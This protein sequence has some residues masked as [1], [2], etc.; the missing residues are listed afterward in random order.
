MTDFQLSPDLQNLF[1]NAGANFAGG[2]ATIWMDRLLAAGHSALRR[3]FGTPPLKKALYNSATSAINEIV[4]KRQLADAEYN[5][6]WKRFGAWLINSQVLDEF[7]VLF[8]PLEATTMDVDLLRKEFGAAGLAVEQFGA[9]DFETLLS[10][11]VNAFYVAASTEPL[12]QEPLKISVL[13]QIAKDVG[14]LQHAT[15]TQISLSQQS[16]AVQQK[17]LALQQEHYELVGDLLK[18]NRTRESS[19]TS[20]SGLAALGILS[21]QIEQ[22]VAKLSNMTGQHL[23]D[24]MAAWRKGNRSAAAKWIDQ[25]KVGDDWDLLPTDIRIRILCFEGSL[26]LES[27]DIQAARRCADA[28]A[29]LGE[30]TGEI[31]LRALIALWEHDAT[32]ALSV[33]GQPSD[34]AGVRLRAALLLESG[35][36]EQC[37]ALLVDN[38]K[39]CD[40]EAHRLRCLARLAVKDITGAQ[41]E[42]S[43]A[44]RLEPDWVSVR[45]ASAVVNYYGVM[46]L[47]CIPDRLEVWPEP[48][49][50]RLLRQDNRSLSGLHKAF[51]TFSNLLEAVDSPEEKFRLQSWC[52][53]CLAND[54]AAKPEASKYCDELLVSHPGSYQLIVWA[55]ARVLAIDWEKQVDW[56]C[57]E[58][59]KPTANVPTVL[60]LLHC[61]LSL[62]RQMDAL[63]L[64]DEKHNLFGSLDEKELWAVWKTQLLISVGKLED[65]TK[66]VESA[67]D[68]LELAPDKKRVLL[69]LIPS[70]PKSFEAL[71]ELACTEGSVS[72]PEIYLAYLEAKLEKGHWSDILANADSIIC[73]LDVPNV[74]SLV[75]FS[76]FYSGDFE[77]CLHILDT[78]APLFPNER[79]PPNLRRLTAKC[80][81]ELGDLPTAVAILQSL[82]AEVPSSQHLLD[83]AFLYSVT[84]DLKNL[85]IV[86]REILTHK[87]VLTEQMLQLAYALRLEDKELAIEIWKHVASDAIPDSLIFTALQLGFSLE[88]EFDSRHKELLTKLAELASTGAEGVEEATLSEVADWFRKSRLRIDHQYSEYLAG[89]IPVHVFSAVAHVPLTRIYCR[90]FIENSETADPIRQMPI[91]ARYGGKHERR[92]L[93]T[94]NSIPRLNADI[95]ALLLADQLDILSVVEQT[96]RPIGVSQALMDTLGYWADQ[97]ASHQ[98]SQMHVKR[99]IQSLIDSGK[100]Q[101]TRPDIERLDNSD[102]LVVEMGKEWTAVYELAISNSGYV[103]DYVPLC[104]VGLTDELAVVAETVLERVVNIRCIVEALSTY[105]RLTKAEV[106]G[107]LDR[108]GTEG[109]VAPTPVVP[110]RKATLYFVN[111]TLETLVA[112]GIFSDVVATF[113]AAVTEEYAR[114]LHEEL[115]EYD[116]SQKELSQLRRLHRLIGAG[117]GRG[118]YR[119]LP[120]AAADSTDVEDPLL[121]CLRDLL[122]FAASDQDVIWIDDRYMSSFLRRGNNQIV[123]ITEVLKLLVV[124]KAL[125]QDAYYEKLIKLREAGVYYLP[126]TP[127]ELFYTLGTAPIEGYR[128]IETAN[129]RILR[130]YIAGCLLRGTWLQRP[131]LPNTAPNPKG[132]LDFVLE[133]KHSILNVLQLLWSDESQDLENRIAKSTWLLECLDLDIASLRWSVWTKPVQDDLYV[134]ATDLAGYLSVGMLGPL[135]TSSRTRFR[136]TDYFA[137]LMQHLIGPRIRTEPSLIQLIAASIKQELQAVVYSLPDV[138]GSDAAS[139]EQAKAILGNVYHKLPEVFQA[140]LQEDADFTRS[141]GI[142]ILTVA[143]VGNLRFEFSQ[144]AEAVATC[145]SGREA[146]IHTLDTDMVIRLEP[147]AERQPSGEIH[148]LEPLSGHRVVLSDPALGLLSPSSEE[149]LNVLHHNRHWFEGSQSAYELAVVELT[150]EANPAD[151]L[152]QALEWAEHSVEDFYQRLQRSLQQSKSFSEDELIG[153][154]AADLLRH[155]RISFTDIENSTFVDNYNA[156]VENVFSNEGFLGTF[157]RFSGLPTSIPEHLFQAIVQLP[158]ADQESIIAGCL[159]EIHSPIGQVHLIRLLLYLGSRHAPFHAQARLLSIELMSDRSSE[160]FQAFCSILRWANLALANRLHIN[161]L[162]TAVQV[163]LGWYHAHRLFNIFATLAIPM[164][165]LTQQFDSM[166]LEYAAVLLFAPRNEYWFDIANPNRL[167]WRSFIAAGLSHA[168]STNKLTADSAVASVFRE[169]SFTAQEGIVLPA[170]ELL[171]STCSASSSANS[172]LRIETEGAIE[173]LLGADHESTKELTAIVSGARSIVLDSLGHAEDDPRALL[174]AWVILDDLPPPQSIENQLREA[175][176]HFRWRNDWTLTQY[177][178]V[179]VM[180]AAARLTRTLYDAELVAHVERQLVECIRSLAKNDIAPSSPLMKP[181]AQ[182]EANS[183]ST[184]ADLLLE[185]M[186]DLASTAGSQVDQINRFCEICLQALEVWPDLA[187]DIRIPIFHFYRD[188][189]VVGLPSLARLHLRVRSLCS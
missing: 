127:E 145:L 159:R 49:D 62:S 101:V 22:L 19:S 99:Q 111:S 17:Q 115:R 177:E 188:L 65:A 3:K 140:V 189:P 110:H 152:R 119:L 20:G 83:L 139:N 90:T 133:N 98:P 36:A 46:P 130:Q 169:R 44:T 147:S 27:K 38:D 179:T 142:E 56:L 26:L 23:A 96:L 161:T 45:L 91:M 41:T 108:L 8:N 136:H 58:L 92:I 24:V 33:L 131:P 138:A 6:L 187:N 78:Y 146:E 104:K 89:N 40:A 15:N 16:L 163:M 34:E 176:L 53:A 61:Y 186:I 55:S 129:L 181:V 175:L 180:Q 59:R 64:L 123:S 160:C 37:L 21:N 122:G 66:L 132:E 31:R 54:L 143:K 51:A 1:L 85:G 69:A 158:L 150:L 13:R 11:M 156:S 114:R 105:S 134:L 86:A 70:N 171:R 116:R 184:I 73:R 68:S 97:L 144:Y 80:R 168:Y 113:Q 29:A 95:T 94:P 102:P 170:I 157:V 121:R 185:S 103:I 183:A 12:L 124:M 117:I 7:L 128:L 71:E 30:S 81:Q 9:T 172:W 154:S 79:L 120:K 39:Y 118:N 77:R 87:S 75:A 164:E 112:T 106:A 182:V 174:R 88:L 72:A 74:V 82:Q 135:P 4:A 173:N 84:G 93:Q 10:E 57:D 141:I 14:E 42:I 47:E 43:A 100:I 109:R 162:P 60:A 76:A 18:S 178:S 5:D 28:A 165:W 151:R 52:L 149:R 50:S 25:V 125:T 148:V 48:I 137:W 63:S 153:I 155:L 166:T 167:R 35:D 126:I 107:A 67:Q 2:L 32:T